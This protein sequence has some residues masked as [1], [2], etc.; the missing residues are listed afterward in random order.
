MNLNVL[1]TPKKVKMEKGFCSLGNSAV[2]IGNESALGLIE[3]LRDVSVFLGLRKIASGA[4]QFEGKSRLVFSRTKEKALPSP[5][6]PFRGGDE[7]YS[8]TITPSTIVLNARSQ[9]G[10]FYALMTL[11]QI[12]LNNSRI[13]CCSI[14][15]WPDMPVRGIQMDLKGCTPTVAYI[16][17]LIPKLAQYKI[18]TL[19]M[20]YENAVE[21]ESLPGVAKPSAWSKKEIYELAEVAR[22]NFI[23][24]M[25]LVQALGHVQ[26]ILM[27][28][29][30]SHLRETRDGFQQYCPSNPETLSFWKKQVEEIDDIFPE[31]KYFHVGMDETRQL[32]EC[33][34]CKRFIGPKGH[35]LDLFLKRLNEVCDHVKSIG[36]TPV[37]W[38]DMISRHASKERLSRIPSSATVMIW[39]YQM[40]SDKS[41]LLKVEKAGWGKRELF[42]HEYIQNHRW[43]EPGH[44][45]WLD[46]MP[47]SLFQRYKNYLDGFSA[48]PDIAANPFLEMFGERGCEVMGASAAKDVLGSKI[49]PDLPWRIDNIVTWARQISGA[50]QAGVVSTA[51]S[52]AN[53]MRFPGHPFDSMWYTM[54]ASA[55]FY[56]SSKT[57]I[58][59]FQSLFDRDFFGVEDEGW[60]AK[61]LEAVSSISPEAALMEL[62]GFQCTRNKDVLAAYQ[63][64]GE[65]KVE[66]NRF[67][68]ALPN[69]L[70]S[71]YPPR[72]PHKALA[73]PSAE[74][75]AK[76]IGKIL[77]LKPALK[78]YFNSVMLP[79][80]AEE[81]LDSNFYFLEHMDWRTNL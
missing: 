9:R 29:Q 42:E 36:H 58:Q 59:E 67:N 64:L 79:E 76:Q 55:Q 39:L 75:L 16:K 14:E 73:N 72:H 15:D 35:V 53:S 32:G 24:M 22:E 19:L 74:P 8:I 70:Y 21:W 51:W 80:E 69:H 47:R 78:T 11:R 62:K 57:G 68:S 30:Y 3:H 20:E 54:C 27:H 52:R 28:D 66:M 34:R 56:W 63:L 65:L 17:S 60:I 18:N 43:Y 40:L 81:L 25:P 46:E 6:K 10:L 44:N 50:K 61:T 33:P 7:G 45:K 48:T 31:S 23:T 77:E 4:S 41:M 71:M 5:L 38:D 37:F 12:F 26:Y 13:P 2:A 49:M 1:P